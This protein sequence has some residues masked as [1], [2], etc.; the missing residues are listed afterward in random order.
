MKNGLGNRDFMA[1]RQFLLDHRTDYEKVKREFRWPQLTDF[2]WARDWF[3]VYADGNEKTALWIRDD[4]YSETK[5][6]YEELS[7][8]SDRVAAFLQR[9]GVKQQDRLLIL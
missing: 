8:R 7:E 1:A 4:A 6:S 3:D 9:H 5:L 2:N